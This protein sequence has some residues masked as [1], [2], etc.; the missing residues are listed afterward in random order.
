MTKKKATDSSQANQS[1]KPLTRALI[2]R[3]THTS[4]RRHGRGW[5]QGSTQNRHRSIPSK[6]PVRARTGEYTETRARETSSLVPGQT[7]CSAHETPE[8]RSTGPGT[9]QQPLPA[10]P[11]PAEDQALTWNVPV[12]FQSMDHARRPILSRR[13]TGRGGY[14]AQVVVR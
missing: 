14:T 8:F 11:G 9:N 13:G 10:G 4:A 6:T 2:C 12:P 3:R 7:K 5:P 1:F